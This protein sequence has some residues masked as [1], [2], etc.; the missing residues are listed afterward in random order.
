MT[1]PSLN[2]NC[3]ELYCNEVI[4]ITKRSPTFHA[5]PALT[6]AIRDDALPEDDETLIIELVD[7]RGEAEIAPQG[8]QVT[9]LIMANDFV[10][11]LLSFKETA[12]LAK[13]GK[14]LSMMDAVLAGCN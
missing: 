14:D 7:P 10:A 12:T 4:L 13:E 11:G 8:N 6:V 1:S 5:F 9:V 3:T 2:E